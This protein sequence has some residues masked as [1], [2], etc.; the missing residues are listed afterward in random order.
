MKWSLLIRKHN[1]IL[2]YI[3]KDFRW[4]IWK[5][6][7]GAATSS[8]VAATTYFPAAAVTSSSAANEIISRPNRYPLFLFFFRSSFYKQFK[9]E[10]SFINNLSSSSRLSRGVSILL[11]QNGFIV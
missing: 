6:P 11:Q 10:L 8:P 7:L 5:N 3:H 1:H 9:W 4:F 2:E